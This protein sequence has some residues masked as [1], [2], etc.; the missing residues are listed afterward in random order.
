MTG[1]YPDGIVRVAAVVLVAL[2]ALALRAFL[3]K[4]ADY[5][6][7][8]MQIRGRA[9]QTGFYAFAVYL[10]LDALVSAAWRPWAATGTDLLLGIVVGAGAFSAVATRCGAFPSRREKPGLTTGVYA[11]CALLLLLGTV[12]SAWNEGFVTDGLLNAN[13]LFPAGLV[14]AAEELALRLLHRAPGD[15]EDGDEG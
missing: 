3:E 1:T 14:L 4:P 9:F 7:R 8:Q 15:G 2:L 12:M 11:A 10:A 6:E 13:A 5:D